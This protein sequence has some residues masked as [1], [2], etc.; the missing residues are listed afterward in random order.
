MNDSGHRWGGWRKD[1]AQCEYLMTKPAVSDNSRH[2]DKPVFSDNSNLPLC[3]GGYGVIDFVHKLSYQKTPA[4]HHA[5]SYHIIP[6]YHHA[7]SYQKIPVNWLD[8]RT[9]VHIG[10][11][12]A[13]SLVYPM[14]NRYRHFNATAILLSPTEYGGLIKQTMRKYY[15]KMMWLHHVYW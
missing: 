8:Q 14:P 13:P 4:Y 12:V 9:N 15:E 6:A 7:A 10:F 1:R 11:N 5:A 3:N 2:E